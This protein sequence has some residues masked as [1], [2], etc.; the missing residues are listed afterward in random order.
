MKDYAYMCVTNDEFELPIAVADS[1][2]ELARILKIKPNNI[3]SAISQAKKKGFKSIYVKVE[4][5]TQKN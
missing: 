1:I 2:A 4:F 3:S 5:D